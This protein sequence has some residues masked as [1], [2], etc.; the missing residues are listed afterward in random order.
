MKMPLSPGQH[1]SHGPTVN[2][3]HPPT[4]W[5]HVKPGEEVSFLIE[6]RQKT[7]HKVRES[8]LWGGGSFVQFLERQDLAKIFTRK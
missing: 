7:R 1:L 3:D 6:E 8:L 2:N 5:K 4:E